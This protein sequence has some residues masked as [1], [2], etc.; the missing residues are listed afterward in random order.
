MADQKRSRRTWF[1]L[2]LLPIAAIVISLG[3]LE[4]AAR[5]FHI[6][7][8]GFW[9]PHPLY[10]WRNIPNASGWESCYGECNVYVEINSLGLRNAEISYEAEG[11]LGRILVLGD[12]MTAAM[13]VPL[14]DT[15]EAV[16]GRKLN[17]GIDVGEW[18]VI[19][20]GIN[21]FGTDNELIFYRLEGKK[22]DPNIV[23]L[24]V[25]LAN[26]VYNNSRTLEIS[27][28]GSD[29]KPYFELGGDGQLI[30]HN[31]PVESLDTV[32][33]K[34]GSFL[35]KHFQLP[36]FVAQVLALR[37]QVPAAIA[38]LVELVGGARGVEAGASE[39]S[40]SR[41]RHDICAEE[42]S[43]QVEEAWQIT[44]ALIERLRVEVQESGAE[45]AVVMLPASPQIT[46][47]RD[48]EPWYCDKANQ[49]LAGFLED[50][51]I[52]Y[53]DLLPSF[54]QH[55]MVSADPLYFERDFHMNSAGHKIAGEMIYEFLLEDVIQ[56]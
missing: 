19:N 35:K 56:R 42:Y 1:G 45:F 46:V 34:I 17:E 9:E 48:G 25:Y 52:P 53:L 36:R 24:A 51:G 38:P 32:P 44:K 27:R 50:Q 16:L 3:M 55:E 28:G 49:E 18:D 6:G 43:I 41:L 54:R 26:D 15:F 29:H 20:G 7:T 39:G 12:S 8:G 5:V 2:A 13:Q 31:F 10:G 4:I 37:G 22:Y 40:E 33:I 47:P 23:L 14:Q 11:G 30:L 21:A